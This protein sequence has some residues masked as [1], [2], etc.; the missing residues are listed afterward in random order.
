VDGNSLWSSCCVEDPAFKFPAVSHRVVVLFSG[1]DAPGMNALLRAVVR[2]GL[3]RHKADVLG[4]KDGY[5]GLVRTA[6][7]VGAGQL[8][9]QTLINEI[10]T[11]EGLVGVGDA[12]QD[13]VRLD[14]ASVSGLLS[15]GGIVLGASRCPE[16]RVP[17]VRRQVVDLLESLGVGSLIVCGG[18]GSL[19]AAGCLAAESGLKVVGIPAT[20]DNDL[21]MTEK[22]VG[23]DTAVNT[24]TWAVAHFA[25][26]AVSHPRIMVLGVMGRNSGE[27][28]RM[29][30][31]A[32]GVEIV[33]TPERG[34]LTMDKIQGIAQRLER[35]MIRA[36]RH[37]IVLV[38]EGVGLDRDLAH[39]GDSNPTMRLAHEL[40]AYF[41]REGSPF[42]GMEARGCVLGHL[43]RG[44]STSVADRILAAQFAEAAWETIANRWET[45]GVLGLRNGS[46]LL[47]D[48]DFRLPIDRE[49]AEAAQ[50]LYQLQKDVSK[51]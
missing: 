6:R 10:D 43:Q 8:S 47:Q 11:H 35:G 18:D 28:A 50:K 37:A 23:V 16:F 42:P 48:F 21:P 12:S 39:Q 29:A 2:L 27:L 15:R 44:G 24:L 13:L 32:S 51:T 46:I 49:R 5:S 1:G 4:A 7:R 33:V 26:T 22:A 14:H 45:S 17:K 31:L 38:A 19:A 36:H 41:R 3:S 30:A 40:Q 20:I 34:A 9:L 25:D